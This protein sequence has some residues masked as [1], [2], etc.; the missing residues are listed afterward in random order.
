MG[1]RDGGLG[2]NPIDS[3]KPVSMRLFEVIKK[4]G[5]GL[6]YGCQKNN[7]SG[8]WLDLIGDG[9]SLLERILSS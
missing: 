1:R 7:E 9:G 8:R 3:G 2:R 4:W 6:G 5:Y